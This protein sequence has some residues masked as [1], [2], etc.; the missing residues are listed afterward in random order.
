M[1]TIIYVIIAILLMAL[2]VIGILGYIEAREIKIQAGQIGKITSETLNLTAVRNDEF[3]IPVKNWENGAEKAESIKTELDKFDRMPEALKE[4]IGKFYSEQALKRSKEVEFLQFLID[5][6]RNIGLQDE[7]SEKS[8][9]QIET[10]LADT[11]NFENNFNQ[12]KTFFAGSDFDP[13]ILKLQTEETNFENYLK[14]F[15]GKMTYESKKVTVETAPFN[16]TFEEL[17]IKLIESLN[18]WI[19]LQ[20]KIKDEISK[21]GKDIWINPFRQS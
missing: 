19:L 9:G 1:K 8:K 15:Y 11:G 17:K 18:G 20:E 14:G 16:N 7:A 10:V 2:I 13:Y 6:Q 12:Y 21:M 3:E 4:D 5:G